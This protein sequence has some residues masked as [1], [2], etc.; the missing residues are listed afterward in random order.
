M[1]A[2]QNP[3]EQ[4]LGRLVLAATTLNLPVGQLA[5]LREPD[6]ILETNIKV[7]RDDGITHETLHALRVQFS[8][9]RGPYKGGIRFHSNADIDEVKALAAAMALKCAVV[10]IPLGGSKGGVA[11][12]PKHYSAT[13]IERVARAFVRAMHEH[14]GVDRDIPAPDVYTTPEIM[15]YML[16]EYEKITGRSEPGMITGKPIALGG[17]LGRDTATARGALYI[18][19]EFV[20]LHKLERS[21]LRVAVQGFGNAGYH[22]ARL[23]KEL[24]YNLV[25]LSDS[26]AAIFGDSLD[27]SALQKSKREGKSFADIAVDLKLQSGTNAELLE[28][29]CDIL[30]PAALDNQITGENSS[31]IKA[32]IVLEIANGPTTPEADAL[33]HQRGI[34]II[35]DILANAGGVAVSYLEWVQNRQQFYLS[36][37]EV[38]GRLKLLM[39]NAFHGV[40]ALARERHIPLREAAFLVGVRR[41]SEAL[42]ARGIK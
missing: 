16:D 23:L 2:I 42:A 27:P 9:A 30:V 7:V 24:G 17:S 18:L 28:T 12:D 38:F 1:A 19:E 13:E 10:N 4:Y 40:L 37:E 36:E 11:F 14:L 31:R 5:K 32:K 15:G 35:P 3:Y 21:K 41:L 25:A 34:E 22:A 8:N 6:R 29:A 26:T 20:D 39:T 33:L